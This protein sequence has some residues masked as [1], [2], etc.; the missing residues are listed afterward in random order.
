MNCFNDDWFQCNSRKLTPID[1]SFWD[2]GDFGFMNRI[3]LTLKLLWAEAKTETK[4]LVFCG[5]DWLW[6]CFWIKWTFSIDYSFAFAVSILSTP[7]GKTNIGHVSWS[8]KT[9]EIGSLQTEFKN[10]RLSF[11]RQS[12]NV[13]ECVTQLTNNENFA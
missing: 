2:S 4:T 12:R 7:L 1:N 11:H 3:L 9:I 13:H 10:E 8:T 6:T 5:Y